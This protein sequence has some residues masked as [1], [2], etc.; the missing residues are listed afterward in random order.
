MGQDLN[1]EAIN[2]Y[3]PIVFKAHY[4]GF[5]DEHVE[6]SREILSNAPMGGTLSLEEGDARS[7]VYNQQLP[8][9]GHPAFKDFYDWQHKVAQYVMFDQLKLMSSMP[10]WISNSWVN[11]HNKGGTTLSHAHGMCALSITA[12]LQL[13]KDGGYIEFKDPHFDL[14]SIHT[15]NND[16]KSLFE[17]REVSAVTGDVLFFPGWLQHQTQPNQSDKERWVCTTNYVNVQHRKLPEQRTVI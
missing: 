11:C 13:P 9:H 7:S 6:I 10:Y 5:T 15:H 8:P 4:D 17:W 3:P 2:P 1:F 16:E 12:Y 14:R